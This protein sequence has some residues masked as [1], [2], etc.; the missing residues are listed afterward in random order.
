MSNQRILD[1]RDRSASGMIL[2]CAIR[3]VRRE[4]RPVA[5]KS[6]KWS[7]DEDPVLH[8][9]TDKTITLEAEVLKYTGWCDDPGWGGGYGMGSQTVAEF[10]E[11]GPFDEQ[12]PPA[13]VEEIRA[14]LIDRAG[15]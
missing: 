7:V 14:Y 9:R 5:A 11:H 12:L 15:G 3:G 1:V 2:N 8:C 6:W 13:L 4:E 10:L